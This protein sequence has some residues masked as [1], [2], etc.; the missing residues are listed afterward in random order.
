MLSKHR[1]MRTLIR[2]LASIAL[3]ALG[4]ASTAGA[5]AAATYKWVDAQ[6]QVH[7]S[8]A[9][10]VGIR[11]ELIRTPT[12]EP[13]TPE[14]APAA[15]TA[16]APAGPAPAPRAPAAVDTAADDAARDRACVDALYQVELLGQQRRAFRPGP[17]GTRLYLED[18]AR[19]AELERL[20]RLRDANCSKDPAT[21]DSQQRRAAELAV[22]LS[23]DCQTARGKL[24]LMLDPATRTPKSE[25]ERQRDYLREHCPGEDRTDL[26]MADW[27]AGRPRRR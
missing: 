10:P 17:G 25:V 24:E 7:Y 23:P 20:S 22:T 8:D 27:M 5:G 19:P 16:P 14:A 3:A 6:G 9:P 26:W 11:Y 4:L 15:Q 13:T 2:L 12:H 21:R 18:E 1:D